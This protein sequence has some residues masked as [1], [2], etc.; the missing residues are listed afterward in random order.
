MFPI[1]VL[2]PAVWSRYAAVWSMC[3]SSPVCPRSIRCCTPGPARRSSSRYLSSSMRGTPEASAYAHPGRL[4]VPRLSTAAG[5]C[6]CRWRGRAVAHDRCVRSG[7]RRR[8]GTAGCGLA[9]PSSAAADAGRAGCWLRGLR[10]RHQAIDVLAPLERGGKAGLLAE[11]GSA[12]RYC[13]PR[14]STI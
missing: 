2:R 12:R 5:R 3:S 1:G 7:H 14:S 4:A 13:S 8:A 10:H 6:R 9:Q 11:P